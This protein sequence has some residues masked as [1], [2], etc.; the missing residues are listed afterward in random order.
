MVDKGETGKRLKGEQGNQQY[1]G[2]GCPLDDAM[3]P[4]SQ[5]AG[6]LVCTGEH[7]GSG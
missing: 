7:G 4:L 3:P 6:S 1:R 2:G 5:P